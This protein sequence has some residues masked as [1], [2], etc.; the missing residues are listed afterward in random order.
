MLPCFAPD[1]SRETRA[2][3][4]QRQGENNGGVCL[5]DG[6]PWRKVG[7][8][9]L[10]GPVGTRRTTRAGWRGAGAV[11]KVYGVQVRTW[12]DAWRDHEATEE[13]MQDENITNPAVDPIGRHCP[14]DEQRI[15]STCVLQLQ[16]TMGIPFTVAAEGTTPSASSIGDSRSRSSIGDSR[17]R[18]SVGD[19]RSRSSVGDSR[20]RSSISEA[21]HRWRSSSAMTSGASSGKS[22]ASSWSSQ[23]PAEEPPG[24]IASMMASGWRAA[25]P[26]L[27]EDPGGTRSKAALSGGFRDNWTTELMTFAAGV[28][29]DAA[30]VQ[31][32]DVGIIGRSQRPDCCSISSGT[33]NEALD[34]RGCRVRVP[35]AGWRWWDHW[36]PSQLL[37]LAGQSLPRIVLKIRT[38]SLWM[39][40]SALL[41]KR[42]QGPSI[43]RMPWDGR[44]SVAHGSL[45]HKSR[46]ASQGCKDWPLQGWHALISGSFDFWLKKNIALG[47]LHFPP[48]STL[49]SKCDK[50]YQNVTK[51]IEM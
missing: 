17:S 11:E 51:C 8:E 12:D 7:Q 31:R 5:H 50:A 41:F 21:T 19:S 28:G 29:H 47:G 1:D 22:E 9:D 10:Y 33:G 14:G 16:E 35:A 40:D 23:T 36:N 2:T 24:S 44:G 49:V 42:P 4:K 45:T 48:F 15:F 26:T 38:M 18:S 27:E 20:S 46:S 30:D 6:W 43:H 25:L 32:R 39:N 34:S 13:A 37:K 3:T